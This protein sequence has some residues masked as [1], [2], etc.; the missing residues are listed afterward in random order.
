MFN[1]LPPRGTYSAAATAFNNQYGIPFELDANTF[2]LMK[3]F[4][5]SK[6]FDKV[7]AETIAVTLMKQASLDGYNPLEV[8]TNLKTLQGVQ[9]N[10]VVTELINYNR[11]KS[12][13]VGTQDSYQPFEPVARNIVA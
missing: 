12:S 5:E 7:A 4:F 1:N 11:Y 2:A 8:L 6:G 13:Y 10:L 3:G 9:L